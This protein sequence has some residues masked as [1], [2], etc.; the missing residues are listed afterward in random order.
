MTK[1]QWNYYMNVRIITY[2]GQNA[3][4]WVQIKAYLYGNKG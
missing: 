1:M 2:I 4:T 3:H